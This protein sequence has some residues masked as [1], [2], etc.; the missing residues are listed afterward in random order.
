MKRKLVSLALV[1]VLCWAPWVWAYNKQYLLP[2][3]TNAKTFAD[4]AQSPTGGTFTLSA[5]A[6]GAGRISARYDKD[7]IKDSTSGAMPYLFELRCHVQLTGTNI[8]GAQVEFYIAE[9]DGSNP[10]GEIGTSDAALTT[11][12]RRNLKLAGILN[13]DQT[14]TNT[15]M[16]AAWKIEI[17]QRYYS[18]GIW[19]ATTLPLRTDTSVHGCKVTP[20]TPQMQNT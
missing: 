19:N 4:S 1:M 2:D 5:L 16:S 18:V 9:S 12:K 3:T 15:T 8:V 11:D 6:S 10:D 17:R 20:M 14:T 13:V 7:A